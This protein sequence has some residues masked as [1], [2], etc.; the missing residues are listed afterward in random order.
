MDWSTVISTLVGV[1]LGGL[2][3]AYFSRLGT[4]ELRSEAGNLRQ[5]TK[6]LMFMMDDAGLIKVEWDKHGNPVRVVELS[7]TMRGSSRM[8]AQPEVV[9]QHEQDDD[10]E[11]T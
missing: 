1:M 3:N 2:V 7:G 5:L 6:Q 10:S 9:H 11:R 8:T 4:K